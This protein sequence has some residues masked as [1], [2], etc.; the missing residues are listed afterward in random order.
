MCSPVSTPAVRTLDGVR[1]WT[2]AATSM[3]HSRHRCPPWSNTVCQRGACVG[4]TFGSSFMTP[5]A[6]VGSMSTSGALCVAYRHQATDQFHRF[7]HNPHVVQ[8]DGVD[9]LPRVKGDQQQWL[10]TEQWHGYSDTYLQRHMQYPATV[11]LNN[12]AVN[13]RHDL[14]YECLGLV[15][16]LYG[17]LAEDLQELHD[18]PLHPHFHRRIARIKRDRER[19]AAELDKRYAK[20][21]PTVK[22]VYD[23]FLVRRYY[24]LADWIEHVERKRERLIND[25]SPDVMEKRMRMRGIAEQYLRH[26]RV[27]EYALYEDPLMGLLEGDRDTNVLN[28][29]TPGELAILRQKAAYFR[30]MRRFGANQLDADLH[31]H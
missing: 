29:Y 6:A 14:L 16:E 22:T 10:N 5:V 31:T 4:L 11:E 13:A 26:L 18:D 27:L 19:I 17:G 9:G 3:W 28:Q 7:L 20:L 2:A 15:Y 25:L 23:A 24:H 30:K 1:C 12:P 21:H 8:P